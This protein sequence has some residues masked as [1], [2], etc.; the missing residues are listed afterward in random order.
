MHPTQIQ[1]NR[2][3]K[4]FLFFTILS[5]SLNAQKE[6]GTYEW[7]N[8]PKELSDKL[9]DSILVTHNLQEN[10]GYSVAIIH[11][12]NLVY[13]KT[14]G[15]ADAEQKIPVQRHSQFPVASV[16]KAFTG[17]ILVKMANSGKLDLKAKVGQYLSLP[18]DKSNIRIEQLINHTGGIRAYRHNEKSSEFLSTH[19]DSA[20]DA[21]NI[22]V[23]DSL[24]FEPGTSYRYTSFGYNLLAALVEKQAGEKYTKYVENKLMKGMGLKH[25]FYDDATVKRKKRVENYSIMSPYQPYRPNENEAII[26]IPVLDHSYNN[27]GG[28]II[29]TAED[30]AKF[31]NAFTKPGFFTKEELDLFH[32]PIESSTSSSW[33]HGWF[34]SNPPSGDLQ[35]FMTGAFSGTQAGVFVYPE[36]QTTVA[37]L[38]NCWGKG[39]RSGDLVIALPRR[40]ASMVKE[41]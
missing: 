27:G 31:G 35:L 40:L 4:G 19:Y 36:T 33:S 17:A 23:D 12:G 13:S 5:I 3:I 16:T 26:K 1:L 10:T 21:M 28:N 30:L 39:S 34:V 37:V 22:F 6:A 9:T 8:L 11:K 29:T 32:K 18:K 15:W 14:F 24:L 2:F 41:N 38:S 25:T 7:T 20:L